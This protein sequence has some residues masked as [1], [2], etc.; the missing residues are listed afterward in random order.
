MKKKFK[1]ENVDCANCASK[2][3]AAIA[4]IEGVES[5]SLSFMAQKLTI[6]AEESLFDEIIE[7][8]EAACK[9]IDAD[10]CIVR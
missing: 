1:M 2:M 6:N 4:K 8:A 9:K 3:E 5:V 7:K 10:V